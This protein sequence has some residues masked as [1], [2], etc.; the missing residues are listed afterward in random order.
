MVHQSLHARPN[1][2]QAFEPRPGAKA[3]EGFSH[4]GEE[5][6]GS[7]CVSVVCE[8]LGVLKERDGQPEGDAKLAQHPGGRLEASLHALTITTAG[9]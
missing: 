5:W 7:R 2:S 3:L 9:G 1:D 4:L 6:F 8:P